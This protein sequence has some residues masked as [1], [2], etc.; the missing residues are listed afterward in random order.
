MS[1]QNICNEINNN[2]ELLMQNKHLVHTSYNVTAVQNRI[3]YYCLL[4]AQK[5]KN[6]SLRCRVML[7][8]IKKLIPNT[9]QR[10]LKKIKETLRILSDTSIEF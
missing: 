5:E 3:F 10:T 8:D 9:N 2:L 4:N 6:G 7:D 1:E